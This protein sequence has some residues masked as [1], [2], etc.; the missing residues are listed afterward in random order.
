MKLIK[1]EKF[2]EVLK[3]SI[4]DYCL[5]L[6]IIESN[7]M[8]KIECYVSE[9]SNKDFLCYLKYPDG[10]ETLEMHWEQKDATEILSTIT[11][12]K[13]SGC[14]SNGC[15]VAL[16][17]S[18]IL[19]SELSRLYK[20][21]DIEYIQSYHS[22]ENEKEPAHCEIARYIEERMQYQLDN[23]FLGQDGNHIKM[24]E[25]QVNRDSENNKIIYMI[26]DEKI[27]GYVTLKR[28]YE[29]IWDVAYIFVDERYRCR[30]FG[31]CLCQIAIACMKKNQSFLYYSYCENASS[32]AIAKKSN[33]LPCA[34]RYVFSINFEN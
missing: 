28:Q 22:N 12:L 11:N 15:F 18:D 30:G 4:F 9:K 24:I 20:I 27:V 8:D 34:E 3:T 2:I 14:F 33:L 29:N 19:L 17:K 13:N 25:N 6:P 5:I 1:K 16:Y 31:T 7:N 21:G 26:I 10:S 23:D 32:E